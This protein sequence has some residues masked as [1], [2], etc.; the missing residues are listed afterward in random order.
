MRIGCIVPC[1][2]RGTRPVADPRSRRRLRPSDQHLGTARSGGGVDDGAGGRGPPPACSARLD[3]HSQRG[4]SSRKPRGGEIRP[5]NSVGRPASGWRRRRPDRRQDGG[6][7]AADVTP[8]LPDR[9]QPY[10]SATPFRLAAH[11][12]FQTAGL[13]LAG[14]A[15]RAVR[16][17]GSGDD[18]WKRTNGACAGPAGTVSPSASVKGFGLRRVVVACGTD[19]VAEQALR[20]GARSRSI[21]VTPT[22]VDVASSHAGD[23]AGR[24]PG[25]AR[26]PV[27]RGLGRE[28][29][30][31][32]CLEYGDRRG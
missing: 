27:R 30:T 32:P 16:V 24:A 23:P 25:S 14:P 6:E 15:R 17:V 10:R 13:D 1:R 12:L 18:V 8:A 28:L 22:G 26:R 9:P 3:P 19:L 7:G 20:L 11:E 2:A 29:P 31:V 5:R 4:G 21:V